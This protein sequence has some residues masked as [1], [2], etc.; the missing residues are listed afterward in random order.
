MA[1]P[2]QIPLVDYV[3]DGTVKKF[4]VPFDYDQQE[5]LHLFVDGIAP[6]IDKYFFQDNAF[7]FYIAP[8]DGQKVRIE[9]ITPKKRDTDYDLHT[10]TIRPK[11]LNNDFDRIWFAIQESYEDFGELSIQLQ[12]EIIA[13]IQ[14]DEEILAKLAQETADRILGDT[15]VSNDL[16][17]YIDNMIALIIGD[18]S[19]NG[20]NAN[21]V[22]DGN[23]TQDQINLYGGKKYDMPVGGYPLGSRVLLNNGQIVIST[24]PNNTNDPNVNMTGWVNETKILYDTKTYLDNF[25]FYIPFSSLV[26]DYSDQFKTAIESG[27]PIVLTRDAIYPFLTPVNAVVTMGVTIHGN[28]A[29]LSYDG[30]SHIGDFIKIASSVAVKHYFYLT[31]VDGKHKA[32]RCLYVE[33]S[34]N[35][36]V[37]ESE[38]YFNNSSAKRAKRQAGETFLGGGAA[39]VRGAFKQV[40]SEYS[41]ISDC[42]LGIGAGTPG[43]VGISGLTVTSL[44]NDSYPLN[45]MIAGGSITKVYSEDTAYS[46]DQDGVVFFSP[47]STNKSGK[48]HSIAN[49]TGVNFKN[50]WGRSIKTQCRKTIV[51]AN[52]FYRNEG[53][54]DLHGNGEV[55]VQLGQGEVYGNTFEYENG[56]TGGSCVSFGSDALAKRS[57]CST[58]DNDVYLDSSTILPQFLITIPRTGKMGVISTSNN[59][60][61]GKAVRFATIY[62]RGA[63]NISVIRDNYI[64]SIEPDELGKRNFMQVRSSGSVSGETNFMNIELENNI[65]DGTVAAYL[66]D[67]GVPNVGISTLQSGRNNLGFINTG[68]IATAQGQKSL[69]P[70]RATAY[71]SKDGAILYSSTSAS[72]AA[73][74]TNTFDLPTNATLLNV[75]VRFVASAGA[76]ISHGTSG[77]VLAQAVAG[78]VVYSNGTTEPVTQG[79]VLTLWRDATDVNK[80]NVKN[81]TASSRFI[82]IHFF[83]S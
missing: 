23:Q 38:F 46:G 40:V 63:N 69:V 60:V 11:A 30:A 4:D 42:M 56:Y 49:I 17:N 41:Q 75:Q 55:D 44:T 22:N 59:R 50:C 79:T 18:P 51:T 77:A 33:S 37:G 14:A 6:T 47:A 68:A 12:N 65:H 73:G 28:N 19:F 35:N 52:N 72:I 10:N 20:I 24:A 58:Y 62:A 29:N 83:S 21:K 81:N 1:V 67:D 80:L 5:D 16:K 48:K 15:T 78:N 7:N 53:A 3:A 8:T 66:V 61:Y 31:H 45:L 39:H 32:T 82:S 26:A 57:T 76:L 36:S 71:A 64:E 54:S 2:E 9:R 74:A 27:R 34:Q 13:R 43:T 70:F 25:P